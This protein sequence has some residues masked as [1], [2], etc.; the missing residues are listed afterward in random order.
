ML[1]SPKQRPL[2]LAVD[3]DSSVLDALRLILDEHYD[4]LEARDGDTALALIASRH[5]DL[6]VLDLLIGGIDGITVLE[7]LRARGIDVPVVIVSGLNT[8]WT[9]AA[10]M[11]LGAVDYVTKPFDEAELLRIIVFALRR[12]AEAADLRPVQ[13]APRL[14]L[15]GCPIG[16]AAALA[17]AL[18]AHARV[19]SVPAGADALGLVPPVSPDTVIVD[20]EK[21][22]D[23]SDALARVRARF[24]LAPII[25]INIPARSRGHVLGAAAGASTFLPKPVSLRDLFRAIRV[26]LRPSVNSLPLFSTRVVGVMEYVSA[27]FTDATMRDLGR[28]LGRSPYY[29]SRLF[30]AETGIALKTYVNRVR[31]EAA[32]Q[33]LRQT[34][35]KIETVAGLVGFHDG[36]HL[37]RLFLKYLGRRPG[38]FRRTWWEEPT[39]TAAT[40]LRQH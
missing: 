26:E 35:D 27:H 3:D 4:V 13:R 2:V 29:L 1:G 36:S 12:A 40:S 10:A 23:A 7:R 32:R 31:V 30:R 9:A 17:A 25:V 16:T 33:L 22:P 19:E 14:L 18:S 15:I 6:V 34:T 24:P 8:A 37:S 5:V 38:D 11:R 20:I 39:R 21:A 28:T